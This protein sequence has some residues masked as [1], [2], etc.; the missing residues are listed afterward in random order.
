MHIVQETMAIQEKARLQHNPKTTY[1]SLL[2]MDAP[3][4]LLVT[5]KSGSAVSKK[6]TMMSGDC[7]QSK[8]LTIKFLK[9]I[10]VIAI[11]LTTVKMKRPV[12]LC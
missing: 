5:D 7:Y 9:T 6:H 10:S 8:K 11:N 2:S 1:R 4:Q 12:P 3:A